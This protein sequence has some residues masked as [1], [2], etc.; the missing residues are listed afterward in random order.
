MCYSNI[1]VY[2][3]Q[4][5]AINDECCRERHNLTECATKRHNLTECAT[6]R[7]NLTEC[8]T[9]R[10]NLTECATKR[11]NLTECATKRHNLT[12]CATKR[13]NLTECA[14]AMDLGIAKLVLMAEYA[15]CILHGL[16]KPHLPALSSSWN[17]LMYFFKLH[18]ELKRV[19]TM[20][21]YKHSVRTGLKKRA[22]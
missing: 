3:V 14:T 19:V 1:S 11:H 6:K 17:Y 7:H 15:F 13:H 12:E 5:M 20:F 21:F 4:R 2:V 18:T 16:R 9:K 10:H 22:R 8:A